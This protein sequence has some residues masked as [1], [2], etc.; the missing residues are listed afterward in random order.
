MRVPI[1]GPIDVCAGIA[2]GVGLKLKVDGD[3]Y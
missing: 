3:P 2:G 1:D